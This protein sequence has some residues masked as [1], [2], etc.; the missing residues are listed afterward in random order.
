MHGPFYKYHLFGLT[1]F[2]QFPCPELS[3]SVETT[4][5]VYVRFG[6]LSHDHQYEG[7]GVFFYLN[8]GN[9]G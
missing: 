8:R 1:L 9:Y 5:D 6:K 4:A 2:S 3:P 7:K